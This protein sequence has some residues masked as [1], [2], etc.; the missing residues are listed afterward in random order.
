M[1]GRLTRFAALAVFLLPAFCAAGEV[2]VL[3]DVGKWVVRGKPAVPV[4]GVWVG[5]PQ[6]A[7]EKTLTLKAEAVS[8]RWGYVRGAKV[9]R[10]GDKVEEVRWRAGADGL[11]P[12][13]WA[14]LVSVGKAGGVKVALVRV[15]GAR[16]NATGYGTLAGSV[17]LRLRFEDGYAVEGA[18]PRFVPLLAN[19]DIVRNYRF[20]K[21]AGSVDVVVIAPQA[22]IDAAALNDWLNYRRAQGFTV[23]VTSIE[24]IDA[25]YGGSEL[26]EKI[27]AFLKSKHSQGAFCALLVGNP[28]PDDNTNS[29]DSVGSV[30]MKMC[31]PRK[32][33]PPNNSLPNPNLYRQAPTDFYYA[34]LTGNWDKDGDGFYGE[35]YTYKWS[36]SGDID[37]I[38]FLAEMIVGRIPFDDPDD[39]REYLQRVMDYEKA[40]YGYVFGSGGALAWRH[41][42]LIGCGDY[43]DASTPPHIYGEYLR[44]SVFEPRGWTTK[45]G[46]RTGDAS[47]RDFYCTP[48]AFATEWSDGYGVVA[49]LTHGQ[50]RSADDVFDTFYC[51]L[52]PQ[53]KGAFVV[54]AACENGIPEDAYGLHAE[55]LRNG[56]LAFYGFSRVMWYVPGWERLKDG[57]GMSLC[58]VLLKHILQGEFAGQALVNSVWWYIQ[59]G[60]GFPTDV[61]NAFSLNLYGDPL[62]RVMWLDMMPSGL[63]KARKGHYYSERLQMIGG[64][65]PANFTVTEGVLPPGLQLSQDGLID[66]TPF[67]SGSWSFLV[68]VKDSTGAVSSR[69]Y[70]LKVKGEPSGCLYTKTPDGTGL[71][72]LA[73]LF[74]LLL[75]RRQRRCSS[76]ASI[77]T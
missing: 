54:A 22:I 23:E 1:E 17:R 69:R 71:W 66:G 39:V 67:R 2:T 10:C 20:V 4:R 40:G 34:D 8:V 48:I 55:T 33:D 63:S 24:S 7:K 36:E 74:V 56:V 5:L 26:A 41:R 75:V 49:W 6:N 60:G 57:G 30:P 37:G 76:T 15:F 44:K 27:R 9:M 19:P 18:P 32:Y 58:A 35:G 14:E 46:Y 38:D 62:V 59:E 25:A 12:A 53:D 52:L 13:A 70:T 47:L 64:Y 65:T 31:W 51:Y 61:Y 73:F 29:Q 77:T 68:Q 42:A 21:A 72:A 11:Y 43:L 45:R 28:D 50:E 16:V 3:V